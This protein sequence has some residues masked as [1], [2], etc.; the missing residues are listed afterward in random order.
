MSPNG[1]SAI[2]RPRMEPRKETNSPISAPRV[3]RKS[4]GSITVSMNARRGW[5]VAVIVC[6]PIR[7]A[8]LGASAV[9]TF[10]G[11]LCSEGRSAPPK[12]QQINPA[13]WISTQVSPATF[14]YCLPPT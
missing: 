11:D 2:A 3:A 6:G 5:G 7:D 12:H 4:N 9:C 8:F 10:K 14:V 1:I 13:L